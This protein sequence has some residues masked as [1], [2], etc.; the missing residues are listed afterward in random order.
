MLFT[1]FAQKR[2]PKPLLG[3]QNP[4]GQFG[5]PISKKVP[6]STTLIITVCLHPKDLV[7]TLNWVFEIKS[8]VSGILTQ[9]SSRKQFASRRKR[10]LEK[11]GRYIH[12]YYRSVTL[13]VLK[14]DYLNAL[15]RYEIL[16]KSILSALCFSFR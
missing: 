7:P 6:N 16:V 11:G 14:K 13:I 10:P 5:C 1:T 12:L 15:E 2:C 4:F 8:L 9:L 3:A